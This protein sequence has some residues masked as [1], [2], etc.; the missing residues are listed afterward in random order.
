MRRLIAALLCLCLAE[1]VNAS[2]CEC[3]V[4]DIRTWRERGA[5]VFLGLVVEKT[6]PA[7]DPRAQEWVTFERMATWLPATGGWTRIKAP[8]AKP[9]DCGQ[10][11]NQGEIFLVVSTSRGGADGRYPHTDACAGNRRIENQEDWDAVIRE[12]G[13][14]KWGEEPYTVLPLTDEDRRLNASAIDAL[15]VYENVTTNLQEGEVSGILQAAALRGP[16]PY[17]T[18]K[19][20]EAGVR[21]VIEGPLPGSKHSSNGEMPFSDFLLKVADEASLIYQVNRSRELLVRRKIKPGFGQTTP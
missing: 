12:L 21:V 6:A 15:G 9:E 3:A 19:N 13:P 1:S 18:G 14:P 2:M 8:H 7:G 16:A 4:T 17:G 20:Q 5:F 11:F 10:L